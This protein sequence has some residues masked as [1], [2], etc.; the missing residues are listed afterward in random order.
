MSAGV[1]RSQSLEQLL[2]GPT[3]FFDTEATGGK[4]GDRVV[5]IAALRVEGGEVVARLQ[6]LVDPGLPVPPRAIA[7]H[8]IED[9]ELR[10]QRTIAELLPE[11]L[12]FAGGAALVAYH[13]RFDARLLSYE[14]VRVGQTLPHAPCFDLR[15]AVR[16]VL[17]AERPRRSDLGTLTQSLG[18]ATGSLHRALGDTEATLAC[19]RALAERDR[20][21]APAILHAQSLDLDWPRLPELPEE[22]SLLAPQPRPEPVEIDYD[23]RISGRR[24]RTVLPAML[25]QSRKRALLR[26]FCLSSRQNKLYH[27]DRILA[28]RC[29][30]ALPGEL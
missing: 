26:A 4:P 9:A 7:I 24:W 13:V 25:F 28:V 15:H 30:E 23:A 22:F 16:S 20:G 6:S 1:P 21:V 14:A 10:G 2:A 27:L 12:A 18:V 29:P 8:G 3:V 11:F 5:E 17:G 19:C